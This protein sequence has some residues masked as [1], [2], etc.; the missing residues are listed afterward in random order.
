MSA[1]KIFLDSAAWLCEGNLIDSSRIIRY[2]LENNHEIVNDPAQ[3]D[4]IIIN[5]CGFIKGR[6]ERSANLFRKYYSQKKENS[7]II[8]Y[9]CLTKINPE[10]IGSLD[11][12]PIDLNDGKKFDKIFYNKIKFE[13]IKPY[14]DQKTKQNYFPKKNIL[15]QT[16]YPTFFLTKLILPF[17][18]KLR[19]NYHKLIDNVTYKNKILV[20]ICRGCLSNCSY[21]MIKKAR[22]NVKSRKISDIISDIEKLYE[23][24]KNLFLVADDC[25]CYGLDIKTNL[26]ELLYEINKK[27]PNLSIDLDTINPYWLERYSKEYIKL[28]KV[29]EINNVVI[30]VQSSSNTILKNMN[31]YYDIRKII[32]I[33]DKI[34]KISPETFIYTH[35]IIGYPGENTIDFLKSLIY[36]MHFDFPIFLKYS[37]HGGSTSSSLSHHKSGYTIELRYNL[38]HFFIN[39]LIFYK[40]L[41]FPKPK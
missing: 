13:G 35:F 5:S 37:E 11:A 8:I 28:F 9:G 39:F 2:M 36:A 7:N 16:K 30:P 34:K 20:E 29:V 24:N 31:R 38:S 27:Y 26:I 40:L 18:K 22:G 12:Y 25:S 4:F 21:C 1:F 10:L 32:K 17:S 23:P 14:C 33:V 6:E 41:T 3:A 19:L 15:E